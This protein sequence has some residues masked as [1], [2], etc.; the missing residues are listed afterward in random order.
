MLNDSRY[1]KHNL[2]YGL[3][4]LIVLVNALGLFAPVLRND[5]PPLYASIAKNM[6]LSHDWINLRHFGTDWLDKPHFPFWVTAISYSI[7]GITSFAY[8]LPGLLFHLIGAAYTY[9]LGKELYNPDVGLIATVIYLS[10]LHLMLSSTIDIRAE[11]YL[12]GTIMPACFYWYRY[13]KYFT[14]TN[15]LLGAI[16]TACA[17][18]T[19]GLFVLVTIGSGLVVLWIYKKQ[20]SNIIK[21][22]WILALVLSFIFILP[23]LIALYIQF[24]LHPEKNIYGLTHVSGIKWF[25]WDSQFGRFFNNGPIVHSGSTSFSHYFFFIH[26]FLWSFL[27]W[28]FILVI[29][30]FAYCRKKSPIRQSNAI[31]F[32]Y[33]LGSFLPTFLLFSIAKFQLDYYTNILIPFAAIL[34]ASWFVDYRINTPDRM[35]KIF[36]V[37]IWFA[38]ILVITVIGLSI[39]VFGHGSIFVVSLTGLLMLVLFI[40]FMHQNDLSKAILYPVLAINLVFI[41]ILLIYGQIYIK[42]D[43][44]YQ[45]ASYLNKQ[46]QS[47][48]VADYDVNSLTLEFHS[49]NK[50]LR[51][52]NNISRLKQLTKP[53]YVLLKASDLV[54]LQSALAPD[55]LSVLTLIKGTSIDIVTA[56]LLS[57]P[58]LDQQLLLHYLLIKVE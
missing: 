27:P 1:F 13:N 17:M 38:V 7:F 29:A 23:E 52:G 14:F 12:Q 34:C 53:Y 35:H 5:D 4:I 30:I 22:K 25:F 49:K 47:L 10:S 37:Q 20:Y 21:P 9:R 32:Y 57:R 6:L 18:M 48:V 40:M 15:L 8:V 46:E 58:R 2:L 33:L 51:V 39:F 31:G 24:D 42:Y 54:K 43:I 28:S 26:T 45:A 11:A 19:K 50:Y 41:F 3:I 36:Y 56:N 16:F 55:K 44:G